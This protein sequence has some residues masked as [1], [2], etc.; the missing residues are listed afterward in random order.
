MA[1]KGRAGRLGKRIGEI[2]ATA[3][4]HEIKDPRL[5]FITITDSRITADLR[6]AT[7][8]YTVRGRT[9]DEEPDIADAGE[10]L[11][12]ARGRLRTMVGKQTG[13]KFTP[14]LTFRLDSVPDAARQMEE[15]LAKARAQDEQVRRVAEGAR[16]AG[17]EDPYRR[18][19]EVGLPEDDD[20]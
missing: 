16:P 10:A 19:D 20:R 12:N 7:L 11:A 2:V 14:E 15:L 4:E 17:D 6:V 5:E 18:D 8:Y 13:V 3:I 1:G 9:L